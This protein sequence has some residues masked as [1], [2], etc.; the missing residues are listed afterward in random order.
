[1]HDIASISE[2]T[3]SL[4]NILHLDYRGVVCIGLPLVLASLLVQCRNLSM[5]A[6][7]DWVG[8]RVSA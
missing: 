1:M 6:I 4:S 2:G 3:A 8:D 5:N 7:D